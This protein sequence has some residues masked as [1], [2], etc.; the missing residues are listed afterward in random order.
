[1]S[2]IFGQ[3]P[4]DKELKDLKPEQFELLKLN[5]SFVVGGA[6]GVFRGWKEIRA[7]TEEAA[8]HMVEIGN[9]SLFDVQ[10]QKLLADKNA[11]MMHMMK[12]CLKFG[13]IFTAATAIYSGTDFILD[14]QYGKKISHS[15][16][17]GGATAAAM[18]LIRIRTILKVP[19]AHMTFFAFGLGFGAIGGVTKKFAEYL[20]EKYGEKRPKLIVESKPELNSEPR[21]EPKVEKQ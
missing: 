6:F 15:I 13:F 8:R 17:A 19:Q 14:K 2:T 21:P 9:L 4:L 20:N 16:I 10:K 5:T 11:Q 12:Q 1:M 3:E 18:S 7:A